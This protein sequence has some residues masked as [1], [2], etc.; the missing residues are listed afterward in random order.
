MYYTVTLSE[1]VLINYQLTYNLPIKCHTGEGDPEIVERLSDVM[2]TLT[3]HPEAWQFNEPVNEDF[4]PYYY[5]LIE[6]ITVN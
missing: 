6:V 5:T 4:A 3:R 1:K 2:A